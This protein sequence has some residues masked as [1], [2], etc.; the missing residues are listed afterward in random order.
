MEMSNQHI[1]REKRAIWIADGRPRGFCY[2]TFAGYKKSKRLFRRELDNARYLYINK[3]YDDL[4]SAAEIDTGTFFKAI[5]AKKS[6]KESCRELRVNGKIVR[7][8]DA[9]RNV[10]YQHYKTLSYPAQMEH[11]DEAFKNRIETEVDDIRVRS[12]THVETILDTQITKDDILFELKLMSKAV[13][14][15]KWPKGEYGLPMSAFGC[16]E[17]DS[18]GWNSGYA[19]LTLPELSSKQLWNDL[20][21]VTVE[22]HIMGPF[23]EHIMQLNFCLKQKI[24]LTNDS[25]KN[26]PQ[27]KYCL[28][29]VGNTCPT[30]D[31]TEGSI[32]VHGYL[33]DDTDLGGVLPNITLGTGN[34]SLQLHFC[35]RKDGET[36]NSISL[37]NTFP[38]ILLKGNTAG[39]CQAVDQ[40]D[41]KEE[42]FFMTNDRN[43]WEFSGDFPDVNISYRHVGIPYCYYTSNERRECYYESDEGASYSGSQNVTARGQACLHWVTLPDGYFNNSVQWHY[44][45]EENFCKNMDLSLYSLKPMCFID[46]EWTREYCDVPICEEIP[47]LEFIEARKP[48][49]TSTFVDSYGP[50]F[51]V[52]GID[53]GSSFITFR[54]Q[55]KPFLQV[56][57]QE[58]YDV[59]A[60]Q[61]YRGAIWFP[62][63]FRSVGTFVS[64]NQWDFLDY[65]AIRC[66]DVRFPARKKIFRFQ[67]KRPVIGQFVSVRNFDDTNSYT[68]YGTFHILEITE[69]KVLGKKTQYG[70]PMGMITGDIFDYQINSS[71]NSMLTVNANDGRLL[72]P[73][74][75]WCPSD[76]DEHPWFLVDLIVPTVIQGLLIQGW[77][78]KGERKL[79]NSFIL[80]YGNDFHSLHPYEDPKG[81][82]KIF[83][84]MDHYESTA[85][86]RFILSNEVLARFI[87]IDIL[88]VKNQAC[89]K[90]E[91]VGRPKRFIRDIHCGTDT[92]DFGHAELQYISW[93]VPASTKDIYN[94]TRLEE[95]RQ[96][97]IDQKKVS[98]YYDE[99]LQTCVVQRAYRYL[100]EFADS[101]VRN[102]DPDILNGD[103][104]ICSDVLK[105]YDDPATPI[106][107]SDEKT[108]SLQ[109]FEKSK[110]VSSVSTLFIDLKSCIL[111]KMAGERTFEFRVK[112]SDIPG[113]G[114]TSGICIGTCTLPTAYIGTPG[115]PS[116]ISLLT[117]CSWRIEGIF[118][119][120]IRLEILNLDVIDDQGS[121][122]K[123]FLAVYD[124]QFDGR[125]QSLLAKM[126]R[127]D[128]V[129]YELTSSWHYMQIEFRAGDGAGR[130]FFG[131]YEMVDSIQASYNITGE[132]CL[133]E[134]VKFGTSCYK[135]FKETNLT[136]GVTWIQARDQCH[137]VGGYLASIG[138]K[139]EM[140][141]IH[142]LM[143]KI[144]GNS[145]NGEA[146]IGL[147]KLLIDG[148]IHYR[149]LD[150]TPLTYTAWYKD[151]IEQKSQPDG[152]S[153]ERCTVIRLGSIRTID[154][155][156]DIACAY[157]QI[158]S[159]ICEME[160]P[161]NNKESIDIRNLPNIFWTKESNYSVFPCSDGEFISRAFICDGR[162]DCHD[163]SD[164]YGCASTANS[165]ASNQFRCEDGQCI[166]LTLYCDFIDHCTD[167][168]DERSCVYASCKEDEIRCSNGQC[169]DDQLFCDLKEDC[170]DGTDEDNC[171]MILA[172]GYLIFNICRYPNF[173][174]YDQ[175]C[176]RES[177]QCDGTI[178]CSGLLY[179]DESQ[180]CQLSVQS[181]C[182][183]M[184]DLGVN[185]DGE[186]FIN[187]GMESPVKVE[188]QFQAMGQD[189]TLVRTIIHHDQEEEVI[190]RQEELKRDITY[191]IP[192][193]Y[194][195]HIKL[196]NICHQEI[197]Y[198]CHMSFN[199][200]FGFYGRDHV[201]RVANIEGQPNGTCS[202]PLF[203]KC[204][205][206]QPRCN[207]TSDVNA[208]YEAGINDVFRDTGIIYSTSV[209]PIAHFEV[210]LGAGVEQYTSF[211]VGPL[212]CEHEEA[213]ISKTF[214]C[215]SGI[216]I[217][218]QQICILDYDEYGE[219]QG[220]SDLS[221]LD[222]C[223]AFECPPDHIKCARGYCIPVRYV[224]DGISQCSGGEDEAN[225][226][227]SCAGLFSCHGND[228]CVSQSQ[229]CDGIKH[230]TEGDDEV[231]CDIDCLPGCSCQDLQMSCIGILFYL[232]GNVTVRGHIRKFSIRN[233]D[234]SAGVPIFE[235]FMLAELD[236]SSN[237]ISRL[238]PDTFYNLDN[239]YHLDLSN[240]ALTVLVA[241]TFQNLHKLI[242]LNLE[243]NRYL[244][245]ITPG[246]LL[247]LVMLP[248]LNVRQTQ[249]KT[250]SAGSF[251]GLRDLKVLNLTNNLL[252]D[253]QNDAFSVLTDLIVLD[254]RG[255]RISKFSDGIFNG[256][257]SLR[258]LYTDAYMFCCLKP[259][260][261]TDANCVPY[262]DE[263]SSCSDLMREDHLRVFIWIIGVC[264]LIGNSGV[265]IYKIIFDQRSLVKGHGIL[266]LN[267]AVADF[268]MGIYLL[269][270][271][272]ADSIYR[273]QYIWNDLYWR[274]SVQCKLAG[275]LATISSEASVMF[276]LLIT[277]DRFVSIKFM[278]KQYYFSKRKIIFS[279]LAVWSLCCTLA[280][281]P[282]LPITY[283][284]GQFYS[285]SAVC[286]ALPLTR[287]KPDGWEYGMAVFILLNFI[288]FISI[289]IGQVLI[290]KEVSTTDKVLKSQRRVQDAAIARSLFLVV[291][292]DFMCW[293]PLGVMGLL[294]FSGNRISSEVYAW[295]AV[296]ILPVNSALNP[297]LYTYSGVGRQK[298]I[299]QRSTK[300]LFY[301]TSSSFTT[302]Y[303][304]WIDICDCNHFVIGARIPS[305]LT[306]RDYIKTAT[307]SARRM[308][309][310]VR[311]LAEHLSFLHKRNLSH[312]RL[313]EDSVIVTLDRARL[314]A[315]SR[316]DA[317]IIEGGDK[318]GSGDMES[319]GKLTRSL[320][321][322][323]QKD[324]KRKQIL[325]IEHD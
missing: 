82:V 215:R 64:K 199:R 314:R 237:Q 53:F 151:P 196:D 122:E 204:D 76:Q 23:H 181:S 225:C 296:F 19:N 208:W 294:A 186:Y 144:W 252:D 304:K 62:V 106:I 266:I 47:G 15:S 51:A 38:F 187:F 92:F 89:L 263:F 7:D 313:N 101:W 54:P 240:N 239:L 77:D 45:L 74:G 183:S 138:S 209:L 148:A 180:Q 85:V 128:R 317:G 233:A 320:L 211:T 169:V 137:D 116:D 259:N 8:P 132:D 198:A 71:S 11:F 96:L 99:K 84:T 52:D 281:I 214:R 46:M 1:K 33:F 270:I 79:V 287:D 311:D 86:H 265:V 31:F 163:K 206:S 307:P 153:S 146:Y 253:V 177:R 278:L 176:I 30:E 275:V 234:F 202:C 231:L 306:L 207:C 14:N 140:T 251:R 302:Q 87:K 258:E 118:G 114:M 242:S 305:H 276:L 65:G 124:I 159:F 139:K 247:G 24:S 61:V 243:G 172:G 156:H 143:T 32:T 293:F 271:A 299:L 78:D 141:F 105:I 279:C 244:N 236:L 230:C 41:A 154:N 260:S 301:R 256:L 17:E 59:H 229:V 190:I 282:L 22:P 222:D 75:G 289:A 155:W 200:N 57:L 72:L 102:T 298:R 107:I 249:L 95:C 81:T 121:C 162:N 28:Y 164:E 312:N 288:I 262:Q 182:A 130:G 80:K 324:L 12:F 261:V 213:S 90:L 100:R 171:G 145:V 178:D 6:P 55:A 195:D 173:L 219:I 179:E 315:Y 133:P 221:H 150:D 291:F 117:S 40:M 103:T 170:L 284:S 174:C 232:T 277:I 192:M 245:T 165:C 303:A 203:E 3:Q 325:K 152:L 98:Y 250:L 309:E 285:R 269:I 58:W 166:S 63:N 248:M 175:T 56:D 113:C 161:F 264:A 94:H 297:V 13:G 123:S 111:N 227:R 120:F 73:T 66:D 201:W 318:D 319:L 267:L 212:I 4:M 88:S 255:N 257:A 136:S 235:T 292:S 188:C 91:L 316:I 126:C 119:V 189:N 158:P 60:I 321:Y 142:Y 157:D 224:C 49:Y 168:S 48:V 16:P 97:V 93:W 68:K 20:D 42:V 272:I 108:F 83:K 18:F 70:Q 134:W 295:T 220:C 112:Q 110:I 67:C 246:A 226:D 44:E 254:I 27:G 39:S 280:L 25:D 129:Y 323:Y 193:S 160:S 26:W 290:Y 37:P 218:N 300:N 283:F 125:T 50:F 21:D 131:K 36:E 5:R 34:S 310:I 9:L 217:A 274:N 238:T 147:E 29:K 35:C 149:W 223:D 43:N 104:T 197:S 194:I 2:I 185:S 167:G 115:Y 191:M 210:E 135:L 286:L 273:G 228:V 241:K 69:I 109:L 127:S 322:W 205:M 308:Y 268:L 10:W 184:L 216:S